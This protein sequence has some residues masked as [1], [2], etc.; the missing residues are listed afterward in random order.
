MG[1]P[2]GGGGGR[3]VNNRGGRRPNAGRRVGFNA[4]AGQAANIRAGRRPGRAGAT[5]GRAGAAALARALNP[6]ARRRRAR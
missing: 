6:F 2:S 3:G 4:T 1:R 5:G